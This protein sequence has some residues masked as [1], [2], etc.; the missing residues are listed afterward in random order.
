VRVAAALI[1]FMMLTA[2][3][4]AGTGKARVASQ[5]DLSAIQ[6]VQRLAK[7]GKNGMPVNVL[8]VS[9]TI[10]NTGSS[11]MSCSATSFILV[12]PNG[13]AV[14]PSEQWCDVPSIGPKQSAFF[15]ATFAPTKTDNVQL[16]FVHPDGSY[17]I[18]DLIIPPA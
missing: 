10:T 13:K 7:N 2:C 15:N 6:A 14:T 11:A 4:G 17:E 1:G 8:F 16:R 18:H 12:D 3:S 9:G 5:D